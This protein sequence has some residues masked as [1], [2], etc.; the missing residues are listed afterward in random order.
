EI[1]FSPETDPYSDLVYEAAGKAFQRLQD[2]GALVRESGDC[3]YVYRQQMGDH[4]QTGVALACHVDDYEQNIIRKHE[5]T[6]PVKENDRT[7]LV[8]TLSAHTGPIFLTYKDESAIDALVAEATAAE[9]TYD[10]TDHAGVRHTV[11]RVEGGAS[12]VEAF[13]RVPLS[14]VADGHHRSASAARV[15]RERREANPDHDGSEDYNWFLGVLFSASQLKIL[16]Y[17]R[18]VKDLNGNTL[19]RFLDQVGE[20]FELSE[21]AEKEPT[22]EAEARMYVAGQWY[23]L[24]WKK[25]GTD[26]PID[27]LDASVLQDRLLNPVLAIDDPRTND[28]IDFVGGIRG[29]AELE[30]RVDEE[31]WAVAFSMNPVT[32]EQLIAIA[33]ADEIMPP[34]STWFEPKLLSGFFVYTF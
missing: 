8:D 12:F 17:N 26:N 13:G 28:R 27:D 32:V 5:K 2:E 9:P 7:R 1:A 3:L 23:R 15:G 30:K 29:T 6:R 34:K 14:Y 19:Q 11:W 24:A 33:D 10:L 31:G 25:A 16:P 22:G 18:V 20:V 21:A 4:L